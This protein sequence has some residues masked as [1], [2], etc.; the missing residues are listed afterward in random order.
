[1]RNSNFKKV[2]S[3]GS[4][5]IPVA[6]RRA[7]GIQGGDAMQVDLKGGEIRITPYVPRCIFCETTEDVKLLDGK[8]I[9]KKCAARAIRRLEGET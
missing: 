4:I 6:M 2:T 8:G 7:I 3:H 1:M 5:N 9:C